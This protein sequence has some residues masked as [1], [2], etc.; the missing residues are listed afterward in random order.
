M[1]RPS[2]TNPEEVSSSPE[3]RPDGSDRLLRGQ[4]KTSSVFQL[5]QPQGLVIQL[6]SLS[7]ETKIKISSEFQ[8]NRRRDL[9]NLYP[10][11]RLETKIRINSEFLLK[12]QQDLLM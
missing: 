10:D 2:P 4:V 8:L 5:Y 7:P 12:Q 3:R 9:L 6:H 1:L 11:L